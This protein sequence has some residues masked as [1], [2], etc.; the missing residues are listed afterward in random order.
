LLDEHRDHQL[1]HQDA[2][3]A[4]AP[5]ESP[6]RLAGGTVSRLGLW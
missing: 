2:H 5:A 3:A 6:Q 1:D 4:S